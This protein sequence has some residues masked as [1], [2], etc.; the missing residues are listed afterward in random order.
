MDSSA[1][2]VPC[3]DKVSE[4]SFKAVRATA[5]LPPEPT[6]PA[7]RHQRVAGCLCDLE[8]LLCFRQRV[9]KD[10]QPL[11]HQRALDVQGR[12]D[13]RDRLAEAQLQQAA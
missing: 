3:E 9:F 7:T 8:F 4:E 13:A 11:V 10:F 1:L 5:R 6:R 12:G 2:S